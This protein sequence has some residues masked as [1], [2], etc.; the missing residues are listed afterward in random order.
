M[1]GRDLTGRWDGIF[2]YPRLLPPN[3][4]AATLAE[5]DGTLTGEV[6]ERSDDAGDPGAAIAALIDGERIGSTVRFTKRYDAANRA[7]YAV[8][9][10]GTL[11]DD[12]DEI[13]GEWTIPGLW[14]GSFIMI[15][16]PGPYAVVE[17]E[18]AETVR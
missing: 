17:R 13:T 10:A 11:A 3:G 8:G 14:S 12:G 15:R 2:S 7:H 9:Y 6:E 16:T 4:F 5:C 18:A 1:S